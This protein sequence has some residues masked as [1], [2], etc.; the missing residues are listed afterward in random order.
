MC[1]Y[2]IWVLPWWLSG[3][4]SACNSGDWGLISGSGRYLGEG[5]GNLFQYSCLGNL[6]DKRRLV[7]YSSW[8][9]KELDMPEK[10]STNKIYIGYMLL[11][12]LWGFS[13]SS[14][15]K[16]SACNAGHAGLIPGLGRYPGE[17]HGSPLQYSCLENPHGQRSLAGYNP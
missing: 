9:H 4:E 3:K 8:G 6:V 1:V 7:G 17:G 5:N 11:N 13:G 15:G 14:S 12:E 2:L 10:L 16:E